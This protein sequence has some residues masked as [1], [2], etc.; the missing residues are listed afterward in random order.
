MVYGIRG[1]TTL[2]INHAQTPVFADDAGDVSPE[3]SLTRTFDSSVRNEVVFTLLVWDFDGG[4]FQGGDDVMDINPR[5]D[6][7]ALTFAVDLTT[8]SWREVGNS[9]LP[10]NGFAK[11]DGDTEHRLNGPG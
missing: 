7:V 8:G 2:L 1:G 4:I 10:N 5:D 11:G 9:I 6:E 3:W